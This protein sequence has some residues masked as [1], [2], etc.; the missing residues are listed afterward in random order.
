MCFTLF[1]TR[2]CGCARAPGFPCALCQEGTRSNLGR[3]R[4]ARARIIVFG[5]LT[6]GIGETVCARANTVRRPHA[7]LR[8]VRGQLRAACLLRLTATAEMSPGQNFEELFWQH[9]IESL[10]NFAAALSPARMPLARVMVTM[11]DQGT[12]ITAATPLLTADTPQR[13]T[14]DIDRVIMLPPIMVPGTM[15]L[16]TIGAGDRQ[17]RRFSRTT[18]GRR[19]VC[20][21]FCAD[22]GLVTKRREHGLRQSASGG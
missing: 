4:A 3:H 17:A 11:A 5:P 9:P 6:I 8:R 12:A 10:L 21:L 15:A 22:L 1:R 19:D 20:G 2:G 13:T 7:G 16:G 14:A 18:K